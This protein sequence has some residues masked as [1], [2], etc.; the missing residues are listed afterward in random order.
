MKNSFLSLVLIG[1]L[2]ACNPD[3]RMDNDL[4]NVVIFYMDDMG[5]GDLSSFGALGHSTPH[6]DQMANE[7]MRFTNY[8]APQAVCTASR[9]GLLT[10]CYPNRIGMSGALFPGSERGIGADEVTLAELFKKKDYKTGMVGKWHLGDKFEFLPLQKGFDDYLGL[11]YSN[12]MWP[13]DY[14]GRE[15]HVNAFQKECPPLFLMEGN[16]KINEVNSMAEQAK[17]TTAYTEYAVD[18]I[19]KN[20]QR[21]FL[22]YVAHSMPHVPLA[23]SEKFKGKSGSGIYGDVMMEIDWSVGEVLAALN[24]AGV[25]DNTIVIFTSDNGPWK[26]FGEHSGSTQGL[27]E[28]KQTVF[29]GGNRVPMIIKWPRIIEKGT[30]CNKLVSGI[31]ILPTL[32]QLCKLDTI[33]RKID[34]VDISGLFVNDPDANPRRSFYYYYDENSLKAVRKDDWKLVLPHRSNDF[35]SSEPRNDGFGGAVSKTDVS[36]A[37]YDLRRD[38]GERFNVMASYPDMVEELMQLA[39]EARQELGDDLTGQEGA[40]RRL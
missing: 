23:V 19:Q 9:A 26:N 13:L 15:E 25:D 14:Q 3:H 36:L 12:D 2:G 21:P 4:P 18:F 17:L 33:T 27:R 40:G 34:G 24:A 37:L 30:V 22:L 7:G 5:F 16:D 35:E 10:G 38:P 29:E 6:I 39:N 11:P 31:D 1:M 32:A 28:G 20:K 8:L